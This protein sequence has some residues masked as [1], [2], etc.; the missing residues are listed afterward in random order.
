MRVVVQALSA[1]WPAGDMHAASK[2]LIVFP[3]L[4]SSSSSSLPTAGFFLL[5]PHALGY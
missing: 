3:D 2:L 5:L 4:F 1:I